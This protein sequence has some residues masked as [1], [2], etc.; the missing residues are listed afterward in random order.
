MICD[1]E[2]VL[3]GL[4]KF[5]APNRE[6]RLDV[7]LFGDKTRHPGNKGACFIEC[8]LSPRNDETFSVFST[9]LIQT[10]NQLRQTGIKRIYFLCND[11]KLGRDT[12]D[13]AYR[14]GELEKR[15][16]D[17]ILTC[18]ESK[19]EKLLDGKE[20]FYY[21]N[22]L[23]SLGHWT[24]GKLTDMPIFL[25]V[26]ERMERELQKRIAIKKVEPGAT[27]E[28]LRTATSPPLKIA[29]SN[30]R[31][32]CKEKLLGQKDNVFVACL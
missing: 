31:R 21:A 14:L 15:N 24:S 9:V 18:S 28:Q 4:F 17:K 2:R 19:L 20:I 8:F 7:F 30:Y 10:F 22:Q 16:C 27:F 12:I 5:L 29:W 25:P 32:H 1:H 26:F 3:H 23:L 6:I 11:D 13:L